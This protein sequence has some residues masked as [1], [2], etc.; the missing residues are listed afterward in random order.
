MAVSN[1]RL[2]LPWNYGWGSGA[3]VASTGGGI[4]N[5]GYPTYAGGGTQPNVSAAW[6][7]DAASGNIGESVNSAGY[8]LVGTGAT[9]GQVIGGSFAGIS[10]GIAYTG[11]ARHYY[12]PG[13]LIATPI[14]TSNFTLEWWWL[15]SEAST[16]GYF[17]EFN[18]DENDFLAVAQLPGSNIIR[19]TIKSTDYDFS[20][21]KSVYNDGINAHKGRLTGQRNGSAILKVD[22]TTYDTP[23][24][25]SAQAAVNIGMLYC[26]IG[27]RNAG[28]AASLST[29]YEVRVSNNLTN[30][31]GGP[32]GG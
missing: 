28:T 18:D 26:S 29:Q 8:P 31:S 1:S 7:L 27:N 19:L 10:P 4:Y 11:T 5:Y 15:T 13:G 22:G 9:Y 17:F 2:V 6:H 25:I 23:K 20:I 21:S 16:T 14:G 30:N 12:A 3:R 32:N 24:D